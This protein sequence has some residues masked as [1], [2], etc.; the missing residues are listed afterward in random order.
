[1]ATEVRVP[2]RWPANATV[3]TLA[4]FGADLSWRPTDVVALPDETLFV[5]YHN[6]MAIV[7]QW[8]PGATEGTVAESA[9]SAQS[10]YF[11]KQVQKPC[12]FWLFTLYTVSYPPSVLF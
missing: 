7:E 1:M 12:E 10:Y 11:S 4:A 5:L 9:E 8:L 6:G 2:A 3:G